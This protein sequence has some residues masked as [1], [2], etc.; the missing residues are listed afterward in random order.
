MA[1]DTKV[2]D[3]YYSINRTMMMIAAMYIKYLPNLLTPHA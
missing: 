1:A 2:N 3:Q